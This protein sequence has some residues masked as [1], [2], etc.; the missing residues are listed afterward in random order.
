MMMPFLFVFRYF[1]VAQRL[2]ILT[3]RRRQIRFLGR[4][5]AHRKHRDL[6]LEVLAAAF[7]TRNG[8]SGENEQLEA[9]LAPATAVLVDRHLGTPDVEWLW[10]ILS[11]HSD[12]L[13]GNYG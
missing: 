13:V 10:A 7:R 11:A 8:R 6:L 4:L 9:V 3:P 2:C 1:L 12:M 5:R